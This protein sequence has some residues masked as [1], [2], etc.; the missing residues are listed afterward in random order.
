[1]MLPELEQYLESLQDRRSRIPA[2]ALNMVGKY[3][4]LDR[5]VTLGNM[6]EEDWQ[7]IFYQA[8]VAIPTMLR[9]RN[10]LLLYLAWLTDQGY[11]EAQTALATLQRVKPTQ[12]MAKNVFNRAGYYSDYHDMHEHLRNAF[13]HT[14]QEEMGG[15]IVQAM[16]TLLW[17]GVPIERALNIKMSDL[18]FD[19]DVLVIDH[20]LTLRNPEAIEVLQQYCQAKKF[21]G[22][23]YKQYQVKDS[24]YFFRS[25]T[26]THLT[27]ASVRA[28][29]SKQ[30]VEY[31]ESNLYLTRV[32]DSAIYA[33]TYDYLRRMGHPVTLIPVAAIQ[34]MLPQLLE[35]SPGEREY[36]HLFRNAWT[37]F[38]A[39]CQEFRKV[40]VG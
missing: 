3:T 2:A 8:H 15:L 37:T 32:R 34:P 11:T 26:S 28:L 36:A 21:V 10:E 6:T 27:L 40:D 35:L 13:T 16:F 17:F 22:S 12:A 7:N 38:Y 5:E 24:E 1:M 30:N 19:G 31:P 20:C 18:H 33:K 4:S 9:Y 29:V 39:W 23:D 14:G 25:H